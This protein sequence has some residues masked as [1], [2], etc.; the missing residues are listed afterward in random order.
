MTQKG[1]NYVLIVDSE[2]DIA[3]L[4]AEMLLMD[5]EK[6]IINTAYTGKDCLLTLKRDKPD[7]ILLDIEL[8]DMDGWELV[9]KIRESKPD[10][11]VVVITAKPPSMDDFS[12]LSMVSNYL[13]KPVTMD[14]LYIAIRDA[15]EVPNLLEKCIET[16]RDFKDKDRYLLEKNILLLKQSIS[17]RKLFILMRQLYP[18]RKLKNDSNTRLVLDTLRIKIDRAHDEIEAFKK[19]C[20]IA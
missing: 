7:V 10:M 3:D 13:M 11:P 19:E 6:H 9:K 14:S 16:M 1:L 12:R 17:D 8:S 4:Y 5:V 20:L 15:M 18:D 2:P